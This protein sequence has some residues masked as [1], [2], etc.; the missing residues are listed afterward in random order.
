MIHSHSRRHSQ[1]GAGERAYRRHFP[2]VSMYLS[3]AEGLRPWGSG[4]GDY[5]VGSSRGSSECGTL[6]GLPTNHILAILGHGRPLSPT[7]RH[8]MEGE[9]G[10]D[11]GQVRLHTG[12]AG[13]RLACLLGADAFTIGN[14]VTFGSGR[15]EPFS[16]LGR[17]LLRHELAHTLEADERDGRIYG[18]FT[19]AGN[20]GEHRYWLSDRETLVEVGRSTKTHETITREALN[21]LDS[22]GPNDDSPA[23]RILKQWVADIDRYKPDPSRPPTELVVQGFRELST[24]TVNVLHAYGAQDSPPGPAEIGMTN[25]D[26]ERARRSGGGAIGTL[27]D[28]AVSN[29]NR[30]RF[31]HALTLLAISLHTIQDFYSHK[32]ALRDQAGRDLRARGRDEAL[33]WTDEIRRLRFPNARNASDAAQ[34]NVSILE[35]DPNLDWRRYLNARHRTLEQLRDFV[36]RLPPEKRR[37]LRSG[38]NRFRLR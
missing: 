19:N 37:I 35:D 7:I 18:W 27:L 14:H 11:F 4:V 36:N 12:L 6:Q 24:L 16:F 28:G 33:S 10:A 32:V 21:N 34:K 17:Q 25:L 20:S 15:F 2:N 29:F 8:E 38:W 5:S 23:R 26:I 30:G 1:A 31:D 13:Q 9:F 3:P 22:Y